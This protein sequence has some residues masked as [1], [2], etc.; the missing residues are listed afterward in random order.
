MPKSRRDYWAAKLAA[1]VTRDAKAE[2]ALADMGWRSL[3]IWEC[4]LR[5]PD[6]VLARATVFLDLNA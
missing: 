3:T 5:N 2:A 4:E 6:A 1:N